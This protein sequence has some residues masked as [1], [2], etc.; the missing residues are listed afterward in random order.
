M[1]AARTIV[2]NF[3]SSARMNAAKPSGVVET[4]SLPCAAKRSR[5]SVLAANCTM[6]EL[7]RAI[8]ADGTRAGGE[9]THPV[10]HLDWMAGFGERRDLRQQSAAPGRCDTEDADLPGLQVRERGRQRNRADRHVAADHGRRGGGT[11]LVRDVNQG[12][13]GGDAQG[14]GGEVVGAAITRRREG[15]G[16]RFRPGGR[17]EF[18]HR[19][20]GRGDARDPHHW[21]VGGERYRREIA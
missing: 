6:S 5:M 1:S 3:A 10:R 16:G 12:G 15:E 7:M 11:A 9:Q 19:A 2:A 18:T 21:V 4:A 20:V 14:L 13:T 8:T 17:N